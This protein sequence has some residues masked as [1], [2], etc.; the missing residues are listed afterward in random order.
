[1]SRFPELGCFYTLGHV[2]SWFKWQYWVNMEMIHIDIQT[3]ELMC[4]KLSSVLVILILTLITLWQFV[5][6][7]LFL[8]HWLQRYSS[9]A[10]LDVM[11]VV[12]PLVHRLKG[13]DF[14]LCHIQLLLD[15]Y[16]K[17][18]FISWNEYCLRL[19]FS[20]VTLPDIFRHHL[21]LIKTLFHVLITLHLITASSSYNGCIFY[22]KSS[23]NLM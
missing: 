7:T 17:T 6:T 16:L 5:I 11:S 8:S 13:A 4:Q 1:M 21:R 3:W 10:G 12:R 20:P 9:T 18:D 2:L 15:V 23:I 22:T 14:F 19:L